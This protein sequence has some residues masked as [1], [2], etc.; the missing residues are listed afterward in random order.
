VSGVLDVLSANRAGEQAV[1]TDAVTAAT[2]AIITFVSM[3]YMKRTKIVPSY[4][5]TQTTAR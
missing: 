3:M 4:F 5:P 1:V 2:R